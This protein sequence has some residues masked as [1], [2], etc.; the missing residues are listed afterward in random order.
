MF[1]ALT[2]KIFMS[3]DDPILEK[4]DDDG[5][6]IEPVNYAPIIPMLLVNGAKGIGTG[7]STKIPPYNP[8][9]IIANL[10]RL[11][12]DPE[13]DLTEM[14]PWYAGFKGTILKESSHKY[15][16]TGVWKRVNDTTI[17]IT[18]LPI[19][20]WT[21]NYIDFLSGLIEKDELIYDYENNCGNH[22]INITLYFKNGELQKLIKSNNLEKKLKLISSIKTSNIIEIHS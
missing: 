13:A 8:K 7:F 14:T 2:S 19:G 22:K 5:L 4:Q 11:I 15:I 1:E 10:K 6:P 12:I 16:S 17:E 9:D 21:Q 3:I 18:E 20:L